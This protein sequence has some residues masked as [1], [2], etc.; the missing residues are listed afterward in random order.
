ML[1]GNRI[2]M[3]ESLFRKERRCMGYQVTF[4]ITG[5]FDG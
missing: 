4:K 2:R 3:D 5:L 1:Y